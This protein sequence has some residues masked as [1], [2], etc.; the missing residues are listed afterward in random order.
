MTAISSVLDGQKQIINFNSFSN[1][2]RGTRCA[3]CLHK[4]QFHFSEKL[5]KACTALF[6]D[7]DNMGQD[8]FVNEF[9]RNDWFSENSF[10]DPDFHHRTAVSPKIESKLEIKISKLKQCN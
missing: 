2:F 9:G 7:I 10:T 1:L 8:R 6:C 4:P 5:K 3:Y